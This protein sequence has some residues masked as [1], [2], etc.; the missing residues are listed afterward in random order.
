MAKAK[1][2]RPT[3]YDPAFCDKVLDWGREGK[4]KA[5]IAAE[6]GVVRQT[7]EN[8]A[9]AHEEFLDALARAQL[10]AQQW[11]EDQ[12]QKG[13][14]A[15]RFNAS[16][17]SRSMAARFPEDWREK[18]AHVGGDEDDPPIQTELTVKFVRD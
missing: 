15:D 12:G 7:L 9:A 2:G 16:I 5:W 13:M 14:T 4:S 11:W 6:L 18:T 10:L 17:W 1:T 8:W 3:D